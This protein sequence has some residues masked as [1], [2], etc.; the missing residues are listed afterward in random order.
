MKHRTFSHICRSILLF[1]VIVT[2]LKILFVGYDIDEQYAISMSYRLLKG[3]F[4]MRDMWEP[5]QTSGFL[6]AFLMLPYLALTGSTAGIVLYLRICGLFIHSLIAVLF[7][8][9]LNRILPVYAAIESKSCKSYSFLIACIYFFSLPKLMFLPE[10]S[11]MQLWFLM[12]IIL[13]LSHYYTL[14][15]SD[16][17]ASLIYLA[18]AGFFLA[19]EVLSYPSTL[20]LFPVCIYYIL[21]YRSAQV[22]PG[23]PGSVFPAGT[24]LL[25]ELAA[26]ILPCAAG[27]FAFMGYLLTELSLQELISLLPIIASDGSHTSS[28]ADKLSVNGSSL[29]EILCFFAFY[30]IISLA[31]SVLLRRKAASGNIAF[32]SLWGGLLLITTLAGQVLIWIFGNRY[33]NYPLV[34]YFF[35]PALVIFGVLCKI[36]SSGRFYPFYIV[37]PLAAFAGIVLFTN[38]PLLVSAPFL[39]ICA[40]GSFLCVLLRMDRHLPALRTV[41]LLWTAVLLFGNCYMIRTTGGLHY[42]L[43]HPLSLMREGPAAGIIAD[44]ETVR[45]YNHTLALLKASVPEHANVFYAGTSSGLYLMQD[46][47]FCTPSTISSPTFDEKVDTYF[48]M[49]T[50]KSPDYIICDAELADLNGESWLSQYLREHCIPEPAAADAFTVIYKTSE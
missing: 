12:L 44:T 14:G 4:P 10:F 7:Y 6:A 29:L 20:I 21:H 42:T 43:F 33:P 1:L 17:K 8:R 25:K 49:H 34:Q 13:C 9:Q 11:N 36:E 27:A 23:E 15:R 16:G 47:E 22:N 31:L 18:G 2:T 24:S 38:H 5:H 48:T 3:D 46:M 39:G 19:L 50:D 30:G 37:I 32:S 40:A 35:L 41:L 26:F 45:K 28:L